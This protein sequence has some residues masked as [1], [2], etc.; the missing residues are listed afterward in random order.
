MYLNK[1]KEYEKFTTNVNFSY[2]YIKGGTYML[3]ENDVQQILK[4][5]HYIYLDNETYDCF[6]ENFNYDD[7]EVIATVDE[8]EKE[9]TR[10]EWEQL[11]KSVSLLHS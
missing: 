4:S 5:K 9:L 8:K 1:N 6:V 2:H 11:K 3:S 7:F 10:K